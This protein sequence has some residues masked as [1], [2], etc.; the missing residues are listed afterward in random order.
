M[1]QNPEPAVSSEIRQPGLGLESSEVSV[2]ETEL[3]HL[4]LTNRNN[5]VE[6]LTYGAIRPPSLMDKYYADLADACPHALLLLREDPSPD[7]AAQVTRDSSTAFPVLLELTSGTP[8]GAVSIGPTDVLPACAIVPGVIPLSRVLTVHFRS[9]TDL[10][11]FQMR[12]FSDVRDGQVR[13]EISSERFEGRVVDVDRLKSVVGEAGQQVRSIARERLKVVDALAGSLLLAAGVTQLSPE[14]DYEPLRA[15]LALLAENAEGPARARTIFETVAGPTRW[16]G[17]SPHLMLNPEKASTTI[18]SL[19]L[20]PREI[21]DGLLFNVALR[22][23]SELEPNQFVPRTAASDIRERLETELTTVENAD[24]TRLLEL[25]DLV[26]GVLRL[27][28][29]LDSFPLS[30]DPVVTGL[31]YGLLRAG[32]DQVASWMARAGSTAPA[33]LAASFSGALYGRAGVPVALRGSAELERLIDS[34]TKEALVAGDSKEMAAQSTADLFAIVREPPRKGSQVLQLRGPSGVLLS[35]EIAAAPPPTSEVKPAP[36]KKTRSRSVSA[37]RRKGSMPAGPAQPIPEPPQMTT[38]A[39][40]HS[41]ESLFPEDVTAFIDRLIGGAEDDPQI[42]RA[43]LQLCRRAG[44]DDCVITT[45]AVAPG[46]GYR[47][48]GARDGALELI[49]EGFVQSR[50]RVRPERLRER[51]TAAAWARLPEAVRAEVTAML[52][53]KGSGAGA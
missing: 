14:P 23:M 34:L 51:L 35:R 33:V 20:T 46:R 2:R 29:E 28:V 24:G 38:S 52:I 15:A 21:A 10:M 50:L 25:L 47:F 1:Q 8:P 13:T 44:W 27:T 22:Y 39:A 43:V 11:E 6:F 19:T 26:N 41:E 7:L 42:R 53:D 30:E 17:L 18:V 9:A 40:A 36:E 37:S 4:V 48:N 31:L 45:I 12:D 49:L 5:L 3:S 16:V 32:P